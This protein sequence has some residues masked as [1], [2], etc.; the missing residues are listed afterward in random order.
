MPNIKCHREHRLHIKGINIHR[1]FNHCG[2]GVKILW[3]AKSLRPFLRC[4][5][6][7]GQDEQRMCDLLL[8]LIIEVEVFTDN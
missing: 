8:L 1:L 3:N 4:V 6:M 2:Q 7:Q 5:Q